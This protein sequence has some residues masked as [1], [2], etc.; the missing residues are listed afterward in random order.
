MY[1]ISII[2]SLTNRQSIRQAAEVAAR[3]QAMNGL[4]E[5]LLVARTKHREDLETARET[6]EKID[7]MRL[8]FAKKANVSGDHYNIYPR[9]IKNSLPLQLII[10][11]PRQLFYQLFIHKLPYDK[12][13]FMLIDTIII[14]NYQMNQKFH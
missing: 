14:E 1:S 8:E 9:D 12:V 13:N 7:T 3:S 2:T 10:L 5:N 11:G 6:Q 4:W